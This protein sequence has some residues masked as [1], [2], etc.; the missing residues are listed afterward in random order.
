MKMKLFAVTESYKGRL[1]HWYVNWRKQ[2]LAD[3]PLTMQEFFTEQE[4]ATFVG[5]A[6][7][8]LDIP[9]SHLTVAPAPLTP[10]VKSFEDRTVEA[11]EE[12]SSLN[13]GVGDVDFGVSSFG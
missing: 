6:W 13:V 2:E 1:V 8:Y 10:P 12:L 5:F 4:A 9:H 11:G 3:V 7:R